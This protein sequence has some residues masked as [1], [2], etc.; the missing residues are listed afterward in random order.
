MSSCFLHH[1][2]SGWKRYL[3]SRPTHPLSRS[4]GSVHQGASTAR[5]HHLL[6]DTLPVPDTLLLRGLS[7][8]TM[9][10]RRMDHEMLSEVYPVWAAYSCTKFPTACILF[11]PH[12]LLKS[13]SQSQWTQM[14][15]LPW[16]QPKITSQVPDRP[17]TRNTA[18]YESDLLMK[19]A[20]KRGSPPPAGEAPLPIAETHGLSPFCSWAW[21]PCRY[22]RMFPN[23]P[24]V[25][26]WQMIEG[27]L[28]VK[29]LTIW[30]DEKQR[31]KGS[32]RRE[33]LEERRIEETES[34]ER[35]CRCAKR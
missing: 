22:I 32:E 35:R 26:V 34:E 27:S 18:T 30:T 4:E 31:W 11:H 5:H 13:I 15:G 9:Q 14:F 24:T 19:M 8:S 10:C 3:R 2:L 28:E 16:S 33:R 6:F 20:S 29:F 1:A 21:S 23:M 12:D 7:H 17:I 25:H